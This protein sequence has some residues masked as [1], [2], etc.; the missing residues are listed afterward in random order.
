MPPL[1]VA[2]LIAAVILAVGAT[3]WLATSLGGVSTIGVL[4]PVTCLLAVLVRLRS[5]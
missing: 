4:L 3:I 1:P 2:L 5:K